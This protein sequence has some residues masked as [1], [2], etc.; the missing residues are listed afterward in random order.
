MNPLCS[1]DSSLMMST[2]TQKS[3][4]DVKALGLGGARGNKSSDRLQRMAGGSSSNLTQHKRSKS[5]SQLMS[6]AAAGKKKKKEEREEDED[7]WTSASQRGTPE[8]SGSPNSDSGDDDEGLVMQA[9][10]KATKT[11]A[12]EKE[13]E[14]VNGTTP[15][16]QAHA[17]GIKTKDDSKGRLKRNDTQVTLRGF[18]T[19]TSPMSNTVSFPGGSPEAK[20]EKASHIRRESEENDHMTHSTSGSDS[21][22]APEEGA[23]DQA[24]L[25]MSLEV[26]SGSR[27]PLERDI[28][29][30]SSKT[31]TTENPHHQ[32]SPASPR[33][34]TLSRTSLHPRDSQRTAAPKLSTQYALAGALGSLQEDSEMEKAMLR[35]RNAPEGG[36]P[37]RRSESS[38]LRE[39]SEDSFARYDIGGHSNRRKSSISSIR[40]NMIQLPS[41]SPS[42]G[43]ISMGAVKAEQSQQ[44]SASSALD[45]MQRASHSGFAPI[46][47]F[48]QHDRRRVTSTQ[49]LSASD[50]ATL[51]AKLRMARG[52][53]IDEAHTTSATKLLANSSSK[54]FTLAK[55]SDRATTQALKEYN[56]P[57]VSI[58]VNRIGEK[59]NVEVKVE[60]GSLFND[61]FSRAR[62]RDKRA[63]DAGK[64]EDERG[65]DEPPK[66]RYV[67]DFGLSGP[68]VHKTATTEALLSTLLDHDE[69]EATWAP[70]L[71]DAA[72]LGEGTRRAREAARDG[73]TMDSVHLNGL[74]STGGVAVNGPNATPMHFL[75]GLTNTTD[76]PFPLEPSD[77]ATSGNNLAAITVA[78]GGE[79]LDA[80][81]LRAIAM[82]W[83]ALNV[84]KSHVVTRRYVDP[85]RE[86]LERVSQA[87]GIIAS[88]QSS[89]SLSSHHHSNLTP[90]QS[91]TMTPGGSLRW[92]G[93]RNL[94]SEH[95]TL[96]EEA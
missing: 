76:A 36:L 74:N 39:Q 71:A 83:T 17:P 12:K 88:K 18:E 8:Q 58:F 60:G 28:S 9:K 52:E 21:T 33:T 15:K 32:S 37:S 1:I 66:V 3:T 2:N 93:W 64:G 94:F 73:A 49:S 7:G 67:M 59:K 70:A 48:A 31:L 72:G 45:A 75:H 16:A 30:A 90:S 86:S 43:D 24:G 69:F 29:T 56:K 91:G 38:H 11:A 63:E 87:S 14:M 68:A 27:P 26:P 57:T 82:T 53:S 85:M 34:R 13:H 80:K 50:A 92:G 77:M 35:R 78:D 41:A 62:L 89:S 42:M 25:D 47:N 23:T 20:K 51:S 79:Y 65:Q 54:Y 95:H 61:D 81:N 96:Q 19:A 84:N 55:N 44:A 10:A 5:H 22:L 6:A 40:S 46:G 4:D